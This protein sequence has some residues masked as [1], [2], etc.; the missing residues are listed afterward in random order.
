MDAFEAATQFS[1][2]LRNLTPSIQNLTKAA[3]FALRNYESEDYLFPTII[4]VLED[5][6]IELNTKS[7]IFQFI[8]ILVSESFYFSKQSKYNYPYITNL[9]SSLPNI[10]YRVLPNSNNANIHNVYNS[11]TKISKYFK[12]D[13][14]NYINKFNSDLLTNEDISDIDRDIEFPDIDLDDIKSSTSDPLLAAWEFLIQKKHQSQ[15]ERLRL[16]KHKQ[17]ISGNVNEDDLFSIK[18]KSNKSTILLSKKQILSRMEDDRESHKRS[19]ESL[20]VVNRPKDA[21]WAGE[22]EFYNLYWNKYETLN[23]EEDKALL[24]SLNEMNKIV[25]AS[26][27]DSQ[28]K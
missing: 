12:I 26:F 9:K 2:I 18:E 15:Y 11:L 16:L 3:H 23:A 28:F 8:E 13:C 25:A 5:R 14:I 20:W 27:K 10:L 19:K 4:D 6:N 24:D 22:D 1:Q 17:S 21:N 7:N